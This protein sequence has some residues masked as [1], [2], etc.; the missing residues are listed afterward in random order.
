[1]GK[2]TPKALGLEKN[3]EAT[4]TSQLEMGIKTKTDAVYDTVKRSMCDVL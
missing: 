4:V 2:S 1:M 3:I